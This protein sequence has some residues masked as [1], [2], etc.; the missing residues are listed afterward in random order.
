[1]N[2]KMPIRKCSIPGCNNNIIV[3]SNMSMQD[4]CEKCIK[5]EKESDNNT[6]PQKVIDTYIEAKGN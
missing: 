3:A 6:I 5:T 4:K 1:M 2:N